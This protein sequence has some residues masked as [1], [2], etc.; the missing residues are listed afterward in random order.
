[1]KKKRKNPVSEYLAKIGGKGGRTTQAA[2]TPADRKRRSSELAK[3]R[4]GK[5]TP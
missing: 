5:R 3:I 2:L 4:W 1:M